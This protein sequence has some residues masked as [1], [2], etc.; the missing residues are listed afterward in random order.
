MNNWTEETNLSYRK[1]PINLCQYTLFKRWDLIPHPHSQVVFSDLLPKSKV[2][3]GG[4]DDFMLKKL[5][6][7]YLN[8]MIKVNIMYIAWYNRM[9]W[10]IH[11]W[12]LLPKTSNFSLIIRKTMDK[13]KVRCI[14][15][16]SEQLKSRSSRTRKVWEL[17]ENMLL[18]LHDDW[19]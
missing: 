14:L 4:K 6:K 8:Q 2:V 18:R 9:G 1:I 10:T 11:F 12:G 7:H 5:G 16:K 17:L 15:Q 19:T 3:K 13:P